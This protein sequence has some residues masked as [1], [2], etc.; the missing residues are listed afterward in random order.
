MDKK[1]PFVAQYPDDLISWLEELSALGNVINQLGYFARR[2]G[3]QTLDF[4]G[5]ELGG[6]V[7]NYADCIKSNIEKAYPELVIFYKRQEAE[8]ENQGLKA[9]VSV[10]AEARA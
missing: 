8:K 6:I 9:P 1:K 10:A 3:N 5:K 2:E 4:Y 7:A